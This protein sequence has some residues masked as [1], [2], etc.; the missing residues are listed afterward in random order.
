MNN[1][2]PLILIG[3]SAFILYGCAGGGATLVRSENQAKA[4]T[5]L[6]RGI[7]AHGKGEIEQAEKYLTDSLKISSSIE[8]NQARVSALINLARMNRLNQKNEAAVLLIDQALKLASGFSDVMAEAAY[9]KALI[10]LAQNRYEEALTWAT[11]SLSFE[12]GEAKG[13]RLNLLARIYRA[14]GNRSEATTFAGRARD[15]N[16][17]SG[18]A[19]EESNSLRLLGSIERENRHFGEAAKLLQESL[20]IDKLIGES[21]KIALDL[22][23]LAALSGDQG[24]LD[25]MIEYLERAYSCLLYTSPS[26]RD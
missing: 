17:R 4:A 25:L 7:R 14:A 1:L 5:Q 23:E 18:Q 10:G 21:S 26:P 9:E 24:D 20:A 12:N 6:E 8:D 11:T 22:E 16:R 13:K 19:D 2:Q 3:L 15:E